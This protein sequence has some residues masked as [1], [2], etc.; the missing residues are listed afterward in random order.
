VEY[1]ASPGVFG[2]QDD[3]FH[4]W[5]ACLT[6]DEGRPRLGL[7]E[8]AG[9]HPKHKSARSPNTAPSRNRD[10]SCLLNER[11]R[12]GSGTFSGMEH[13]RVASG[14]YPGGRKLRDSTAPASAKAG[15]GAFFAAP[16]LPPQF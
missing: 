4:K 9:L 11:L 12:T 3:L 16:W 2:L 13:F 6:R 7:A 14:L 8:L 10:C 15:A 5:A 1:G